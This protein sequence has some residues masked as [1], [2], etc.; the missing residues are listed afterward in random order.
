M[1]KLLE[2][3]RVYTQDN[4][5]PDIENIIAMYLNQLDVHEKK[6]KVLASVEVDY[7]HRWGVDIS[8]QVANRRIYGFLYCPLIRQDHFP[9]I[10]R[11][12]YQGFYGNCDVCQHHFFDCLDLINKLEDQLIIDPKP[13]SI[14]GSVT[15]ETY[16]EIA[17][18]Y[19]EAL[20][21]IRL[22]IL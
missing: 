17:R 21:F 10:C 4:L 13:L 20:Q 5:Y 7:L 12:I 9:R 8:H 16:R 2:K 1:D 18:I 19:T 3:V 15:D 11:G 22:Y 14:Y 6:A